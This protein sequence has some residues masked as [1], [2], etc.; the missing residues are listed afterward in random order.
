MIP[1]HADFSDMLAHWAAERP[2]AADARML[3]EL[4]RTDRHNHRRVAGDSVAAEGLKVLARAHQTLIWD[5]SR[6]VARLRS[7]LREYFPAALT[8]FPVLDDR[9]ALAVLVRAPT[10][11]L[12][13]RLSLAKIGSA[14]RAGGRKRNIDIRAAQ[15]AEGS[16]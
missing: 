6:A 7:S 13:K 16:H 9:D 10:P 11:D 5:R 14:L 8:T 12:A 2:D 1:D 3:A 15:I 4:V